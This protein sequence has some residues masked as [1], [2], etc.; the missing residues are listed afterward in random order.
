[1]I[2]PSISAIKSGVRVNAATRVRS[3]DRD[4]APL[5][6]DFTNDLEELVVV[7]RRA[8]SSQSGKGAIKAAG[9]PASRSSAGVLDQLS[10]LKL[11]G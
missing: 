4:E 1:M 5:T 10:R 8:R 11:G 2:I 3:V 9:S 7:R 6:V